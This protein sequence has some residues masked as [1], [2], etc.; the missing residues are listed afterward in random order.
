[1]QFSWVTYDGAYTVSINTAGPSRPLWFH[2][3]V[4]YFDATYTGVYYD[5]SIRIRIVA[6]TN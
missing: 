5:H 6:A 1:M 4:R 3:I 2:L